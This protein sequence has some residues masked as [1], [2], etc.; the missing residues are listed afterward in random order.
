[1]SDFHLYTEQDVQNFALVYFNPKATQDKLYSALQ[2]VLDRFQEAELDDQVGFRGTLNDYVRLYAFLSQIVPFADAGLEKLYVFGRFLLRRLPVT[3]DELPTEI[4]KNIDMDSYRIQKVR[5]GKILLERGEGKLLPVAAE[6]G[7]LIPVEDLEPLS[8]IVKELN[9]R[10]GTDFADEDKVFI[11]QLEQ[12]LAGDEALRLSVRTNTEEN[13]RLTFDHVL[14]DRLQD[15][16]D[17]NFKFYKRITDDKQFGKFFL[18]WLFERFLKEF[19][20][21]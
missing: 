20:R 13:A 4:Q 18:D 9:E 1:L 10:F 14:N 15:M 17:T 11:Q 12:K 21:G 8:Q 7:H 2:P 3:R 19:K 5:N 6:A 16:I